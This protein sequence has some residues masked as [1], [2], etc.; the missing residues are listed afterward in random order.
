MNVVM[1]QQDCVSVDAVAF[2]PLLTFF[3]PFFIIVHMSTISDALLM[4]YAAV[5][6]GTESDSESMVCSHLQRHLISVWKKKLKVCALSRGH[7][8]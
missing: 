3:S 6:T 7:T 2:V 1:S 8:M 5:H 4:E